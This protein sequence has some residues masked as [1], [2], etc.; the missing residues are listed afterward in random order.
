MLIRDAAGGGWTPTPKEARKVEVD[1]RISDL[2]LALADQMAKNTELEQRQQDSEL[3]LADI[4][5]GGV[6]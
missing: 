1:Q 2:E 3:A 4:I 5:A 6:S